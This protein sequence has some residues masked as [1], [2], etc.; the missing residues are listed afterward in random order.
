MSTVNFCPAQASGKELAESKIAVGDQQVL[1]V[2]KF[3]I[4]ATEYI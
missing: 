2:N 3:S 4:M 1:R